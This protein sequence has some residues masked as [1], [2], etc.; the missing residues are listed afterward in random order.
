MRFH[1]RRLTPVRIGVLLASL[2]LAPL[3][4]AQFEGGGQ[5]IPPTEELVQVSVA[6]VD[7]K[8]GTTAEAVV[9]LTIAQGWHI[10]ANPPSPDL[11]PTT[12]TVKPG[13][14][15][16]AGGALYPPAHDEKL[17][18]SDEA[19]RVYD[20]TVS[21]RVP[22]AIAASAPNGRQTLKGTLAFQSC[23]NQVCLPPARLPFT[24][25]V[26]V[27]GGGAPASAASDSAPPTGTAPPAGAEAA[28]APTAE[29]SASWGPPPG[30]TPGAAAANPTG[31]L[32]WLT[33][34]FPSADDVAAMMARGGIAWFLFLFGGGLVLNL[35]PCVFP[36]LGITVSLFGARRREPPAKVMTHAGAYV[37][38]IVLTYSVL[39]VI[40]GMTGGL[41]GAMLQNP[42]VL[43][44][45]GILILTLSLSMFGV[46]EFQPPAWLLTKA[47]GADASSLIGI[48]VSGLAVG[49]IAA[50]CVGP[51]VVAVLALIAQR[52]DTLFGFQTM[53]AMALGL[54]FPYL[55][56]AT[57]SN[58]LQTLPRSGDWMVWV[59]KVFGV[60]MVA[61][62][63]NYV[64]TGIRAEWA[65]W[66]TPIALVLGGL[67]LGFIDRHG[68]QKPRFR[69]F[70]WALGA[71]AIVGGS[72]AGVALRAEG[73]RFQHYQEEA[74]TAA[75]ASGRPVIMDFSA[76][77]CLPCHELDRNTF[78]HREV[79]DLSRQF[80]M[81]KVDMTYDSPEARA[82]RQRFGVKGVPE[83]LFF[84]PGGEEVRMARVVGFVEPEPFLERMRFMLAPR[85]S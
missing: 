54:G 47:S 32:G 25:E 55:F 20:G 35:T 21:I 10:N 59:K 41:F 16:T 70:K 29:D 19:V 40:A 37:L 11:I 79:I 27:T 50:P 34:L 5:A 42:I 57:F 72:F 24:V 17:S 49:L 53:F 56:L 3:A 82:L 23:N 60:L 22:I 36:M 1:P 85:R 33:G 68:S 69:T 64:M 78:T 65:P 80:A 39:G 44:G 74:V 6:A 28:P 83:V 61:I 77:W 73:V 31:P 12:V 15:T 58:L 52:G 71:A 38:G 62:G 45:I 63:L 43:M 18:F 4:H 14:G 66:V 81:F 26:M 75:F 8:A 84:L 2:L 30:W 51:F 67:Y 13:A 46:Y 9:T 7:A 76:S 48:F